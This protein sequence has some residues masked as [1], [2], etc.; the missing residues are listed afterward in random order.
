MKKAFATSL[1]ITCAFGMSAHAQST[2]ER[3]IFALTTHVQSNPVTADGAW[4]E[5]QNILSEW[6]RM[7]LVFGYGG[8]GDFA[9]CEE[10]KNFAARNNP[11][12]SFRCNP[13]N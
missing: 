7:I 8:N 9:A 1:V 3:D 5:M 6:E 2:Y 13:V 10:I 12:R 4:L 11:D